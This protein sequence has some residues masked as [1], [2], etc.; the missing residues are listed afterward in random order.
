M[1]KMAFR[2][3]K[4]FIPN[5]GGL[6]IAVVQSLQIR[7]ECPEEHF[8]AMKRENYLLSFLI[9]WISYKTY[10]RFCESKISRFIS[11]FTPF[12]GRETSRENV[13]NK[14][15]RDMGFLFSL[16]PFSNHLSKFYFD[17]GRSFFI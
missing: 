1:D 16:K 15:W 3:S 7:F 17:F 6:Q 14:G 8:L 10:V 5:V 12:R 2:Q 4:T 13:K 9:G 11:P